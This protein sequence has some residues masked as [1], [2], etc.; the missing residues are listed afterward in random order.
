MITCPSCGAA[1]FLLH[2][3]AITLDGHR[4]GRTQAFIEHALD[5]DSTCEG[6]AC[7]AYECRECDCGC[8]RYVR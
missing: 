7:K 5:R 3:F 2:E 8:R 1:M 6:D 4:D